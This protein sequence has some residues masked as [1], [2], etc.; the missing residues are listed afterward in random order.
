MMGMPP[1]A[2]LPWTIAPPSTTPWGASRSLSAGTLAPPVMGVHQLRV[3][4][5]KNLMTD[6]LSA[7]YLG[8]CNRVCAGE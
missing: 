4:S 6:R 2:V 7:W 1:A 8:G 3:L 5:S